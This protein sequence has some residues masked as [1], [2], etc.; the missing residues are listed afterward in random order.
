MEDE[1]SFYNK[2]SL[3]ASINR[4]GTLDQ[5]HYWDVVKDLNSEN[6]LSCNDKVAVTVPQHSLNN[7]TSYILHYKKI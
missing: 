7:T 1:V 5:V 6:W 3:V 4:S 2:Y